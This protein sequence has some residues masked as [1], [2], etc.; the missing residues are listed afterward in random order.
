MQLPAK[1]PPDRMCQVLERKHASIVY[2]FH[3]IWRRCLYQHFD[4]TT[5]ELL[6]STQNPDGLTEILHEDPEP[7]PISIPIPPILEEVGAGVLIAD[8]TDEVMLMSMMAK[9][10]MSDSSKALEDVKQEEAAQ[11]STFS[12]EGNVEESRNE[13]G[14]Q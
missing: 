1:A 13:H 12:I 11:S 10:L 4:K 14:A 3:S 6:I 8:D 2:Q 9:R 5:R 7:I